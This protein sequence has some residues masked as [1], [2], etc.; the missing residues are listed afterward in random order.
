MT[1]ASLGVVS[2]SESHGHRRTPP[3]RTTIEVAPED[4]RLVLQAAL[5]EDLGW[6]RAY[7]VLC[8][9]LHRLPDS[10]IWGDSFAAPAV[11]TL[12]ENDFEWF[13]VFDLL[14]KYGDPDEVNKSFAR[15]GLAYEMVTSGRRQ[16]IRLLDPEGDLLKV[17]GLEDEATAVLDEKFKDVSEQWTRALKALRS[18]PTDPEKAVGEAIGALEAVVR[19]L[20]GH[21][22]FGKNVDAIFA[23]EPSW[24]KALAASMKSLY[25]YS[26]QTPGVRHGRYTDSLLEQSEATYVAR[27]CGSAIAYLIAGDRAGRWD[28]LTAD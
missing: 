15:T 16:A 8:E 6:V 27:I 4:L 2:F 12:I 11:R 5:V 23:N 14:E 3:P 19:I 20:A 24:A 1:T 18:R 25:G 13:E 28:H 22:D 17:A 10:R 7:Q 26:S 21:K 9:A